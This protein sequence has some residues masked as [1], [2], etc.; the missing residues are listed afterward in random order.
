MPQERS[1]RRLAYGA[2]TADLFRRAAGYVDRI[3]RG[4]DPATMPVELPTKFDFAVNVKAARARGLASP[5]S[6]L[7]R[8]TRVI[9]YAR[10]CLTHQNSGTALSTRTGIAVPSRTR[11]ARYCV[12]NSP[13]FWKR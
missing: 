7:L 8:A 13:V 4:A 6:V 2:S 3:L 12:S 1:P 10:A 5:G 9:E 11:I